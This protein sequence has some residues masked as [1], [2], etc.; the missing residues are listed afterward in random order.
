MTVTISVVVTGQYFSCP[1]KFP[2]PFSQVGMEEP[3]S[4]PHK[5]RQ[6]LR[7]SLSPATHGFVN[8]SPDSRRMETRNGR[9]HRI[10]DIKEPAD[11]IAELKKWLDRGDARDATDAE[12]TRAAKARTA[13]SLMATKKIYKF[14]Q[15]DLATS[16]DVNP[17]LSK[18]DFEVVQRVSF[19]V[20]QH[21]VELALKA[22]VETSTKRRRLMQ[23]QDMPH[24]TVEFLRKM[25]PHGAT[26]DGLWAVAADACWPTPGFT[27]PHG[28]VHFI[29]IDTGL[30]V[31]VAHI[32]KQGT[33]G[34]DQAA[35]EACCDFILTG[36]GSSSG[37][38]DQ[39]GTK[40]C[41]EWLT[42]KFPEISKLILL[43]RDGDVKAVKARELSDNAEPGGDEGKCGKT[44]KIAYF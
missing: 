12:K 16:C 25:F 32:T 18:A 27:S 11:D 37:M 23:K 30:I 7:S 33:S 3:A 41:A 21:L 19:A 6:L 17:P 10:S 24:A 20:S 39:A 42:R 15:Y 5:K 43:C 36:H 29:D 38:M 4:P 40:L 1:I 8:Q 2:S 26:K 14:H 13:L 44:A 31:A 9:V 28:T 22:G 35:L 34:K